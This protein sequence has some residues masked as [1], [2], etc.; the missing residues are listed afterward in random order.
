VA[1]PW[2]DRESTSLIHVD[3]ATLF[4]CR[5]SWFIGW[6]SSS[7]IGSGSNVSFLVDCTFV[8]VWSEW[9]FIVASDLGQGMCTPL[10]VR[11]GQDWKNPHLMAVIHVD[12]TGLQ[13]AAWRNAI[14]APNSHDLVLGTVAFQSGFHHFIWD[15]LIIGKWSIPESSVVAVMAHYECVVVLCDVDLLS[16]KSGLA[17]G[18]TCFTNNGE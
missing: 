10:V 8:L 14:K 15:A 13:V 16:I 5:K 6:L 18:I 3:F 17:S 9:P 1:L 4:V 7:L 2:G 12:A 11:P